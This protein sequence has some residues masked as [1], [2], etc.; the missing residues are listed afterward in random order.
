[1]NETPLNRTLAPLLTRTALGMLFFFAGLNKFLGPGPRGFMEYIVKEFEKTFL[2]SWSL[3]P[4]AYGL[5]FAELG[6]GLFLLAGLYR[7]I[8]LFTTGLLLLSLGFG[9]IL[10]GNHATVASIFLYIFLAA[11]TL[12]HESDDTFSMDQLISR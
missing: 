9:Q 3:M 4:Y 6:L 7:R 11:W 10:L 12:A 1:M 2:P 5:P 8:A